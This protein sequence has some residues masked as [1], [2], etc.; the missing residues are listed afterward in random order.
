MDA[1]QLTKKF[2]LLKGAKGLTVYYCA[3]HDDTS[4]YKNGEPPTR[5]E[6]GKFEDKL[7]RVLRLMK[8]EAKE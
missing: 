6:M 5:C 7:R 1:C 8:A 4:A 3:T 2:V